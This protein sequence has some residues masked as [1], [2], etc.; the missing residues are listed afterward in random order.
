[1]WGPV[2]RLAVRSVQP[3]LCL[4]GCPSGNATYLLAQK[5]S[6]LLGELLDR[7]LDARSLIGRGCSALDWLNVLHGE[8]CVMIIA[9]ASMI[10]QVQN[11]QVTELAGQIEHAT[12]SCGSIS[13]G[14][15]SKPL[16]TRMTA[17]LY[18]ACLLS[19]FSR[20]SWFC[21]HRCI[22]VPGR[23]AADCLS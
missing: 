8:R 16:S 17:Q 6:E 5:V 11:S 15:H 7:L 19:L 22:E 1:M 21:A 18:K 3:K 4:K 13:D 20:I 23:P 12:A 9:C 14:P 10:Q 2:A